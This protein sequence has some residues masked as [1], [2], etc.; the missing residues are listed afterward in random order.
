MDGIDAALIETDSETRTQPLH[1]FF[2]PYPAYF[3]RLLKA[4]QYCVHQEKAQLAHVRKNFHRRLRARTQD[5]DD[6]LKQS[7]LNDFAQTLD[8]DSLCQASTQLHENA[9][10]ALLKQTGF[11][12]QDI[13]VIG[14]HGQTLY[15]QPQAKRTLQIGN[16]QQLAN[17]TRITTVADFRREDIAHGGQGAPLAPLYHYAL[18]Q[19]HH[20]TPLVI[21]N[22]G[23]I[24]N[25]TCIPSANIDT[26][27]GFDVGP[28]NTLIDRYVAHK[29]NQRMDE[30]GRYAL[31]GKVL[32]EITACLYRD[33]GLQNFAQK[34]APKSL[35]TNDIILPPRLLNDKYAL[36]DV[37]ASLVDFTT[38]HIADAVQKTPIKRVVLAG[39][40]WHNLA[41]LKSLKQKLPER[42]I[43]LA[44]DVGFHNDAL[45]AQCFAY[46]AARRLQQKTTHYPNITGVSKTLCA[47]LL[48]KPV[49]L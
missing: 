22:C 20:L 35:D 33:A 29:T 7:F 23:G 44:K 11:C 6:E 19:Q 31:S 25:I 38:Q 5:A 24:A 46:L 13:D 4:A 30:N 26:V 49:V 37:C 18:A 45:E 16:A 2:L 15:H 14:Y 47:G 40:G 36:A 9:V 43:F 28:G 3:Q 48:V 10:A 1:F 41:L 42:H 32:P 27:T 12:A 21:I 17:T 34:K 8:F 39:G